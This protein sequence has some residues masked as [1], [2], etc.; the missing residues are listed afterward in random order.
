MS[1]TSSD[2]ASRSL[3][4]TGQLIERFGARESGTAASRAAADALL[5]EAKTFA[6]SAWTEDFSVK[7]KAFLGWI[8]VLV[9][10]YIVC[11]IA[12]WLDQFLLAALLVTI[13]LLIMVGQ[14]FLYREWLDP[15]FPHQIGRNVLATIE[16]EGEARGQL[17]I[18]GHH[19]SA[20]VF[21]FL[22][23]QPKL[24]PLRVMGSIGILILLFIASWTLVIWH[25]V[26]GV[27][28]NWATGV[29]GF[30]T[31][32][33]LL[34]GQLWWFASAESTPGAGDN[35][36][37][38]AA[39]WQV[40][41]IL[42]RQKTAGNGLQH[43]RIIAASWDAEEAGLR[44]ARAWVAQKSDGRLDLPTW[45]LNLECLY[46]EE[47]LFLLTSDINGTVAL[48]AELA[49]RCQNLLAN[50]SI[51]AP[52]KP[53]AFLTGGTDAAELAKAGA[54]AT[55]LLGMPWG[56]STRSSVYH[57]PADLLES[58]SPN[59]VAIAID[60]GLDLAADIDAELQRAQYS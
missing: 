51:D 23:H 20:F 16:P 37:S 3:A 40:G 58:V 31:L 48:S 18:S 56:N 14:F 47:D 42:S 26:G 32:L 46:S 36:A 21:N 41:H 4:F 34:V 22:I 7:P 15:F 1:P 59:A 28:P 8:R 38:T 17:I 6:D 5:A 35:L 12:L 43:L 19:D 60:L 24:Y 39:A 10:I 55:T 13:G 25:A 29:A 30:F 27:P 44:G 57:T 45:N 52:T 33:L 49:N 50:H 9:V 11:L 53:I 2:A 54:Q